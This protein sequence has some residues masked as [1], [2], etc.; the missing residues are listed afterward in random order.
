MMTHIRHGSRRAMLRM[1]QPSYLTSTRKTRMPLATSMPLPL[2]VS[3]S[4]QCLH[5]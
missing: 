2:V 3:T 5:H 1:H 4:S